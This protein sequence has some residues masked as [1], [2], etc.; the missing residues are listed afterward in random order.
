M[1][2]EGGFV[3]RVDLFMQLS[4]LLCVL[5][6]FSGTVNAQ[7][8]AAQPMAPLASVQ[9][10]AVITA[11][12]NLR[13]QP[14]MQGAVLTVVQ[15]ETVV[16]TLNKSGSWEHVQTENGT[17]GWIHTSLLV[18]SQKA[19]ILHVVPALAPASLPQQRPNEQQAAVSGTEQSVPH[20]HST[21][22]SKKP[23][24]FPS[25]DLLLPTERTQP[26]Q[27]ATLS[28]ARR[29]ILLAP[30]SPTGTDDTTSIT[31]SPARREILLAPDSPVDAAQP[32]QSPIFPETNPPPLED[33]DT[34]ASADKTDTGIYEDADEDGGLFGRS[35]L[36]Y[37]LAAL[38]VG[39]LGIFVFQIKKAREIK[40]HIYVFGQDTRYPTLTWQPGDDLKPF[41][42]PIQAEQ[43]LEAE[44]TDQKVQDPAFQYQ[45]DPFLQQADA[46][47]A[48]QDQDMP[49]VGEEESF[50]DSLFLET[51]KEDSQTA[52]LKDPQA[53]SSAGQPVGLIEPQS[54]PPEQPSFSPDNHP[55]NYGEA[56]P[57]QEFSSLPPL[58][59]LPVEFSVVEKAVL[60]A[61][62]TQEE[63]PE[64]ELKEMLAK[65]GFPVMLLKAVIGD[66]MRKTGSNGIPWIRVHYTQGAFRYQRQYLPTH[67]NGL[68]VKNYGNGQEQVTNG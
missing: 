41:L 44:Q 45:E 12:A 43:P 23:L 56:A 15:A 17:F 19:G 50:I 5:S 40:Q 59:D 30:D 60:E 28:P 34:S 67:L 52:S 26:A 33:R 47:L 54:I 29:E 37:I 68:S 22:V 21:S 64:Y 8:Q 62:F 27:H 25:P 16:Q 11:N 53:A 35:R 63:V 2:S 57:A 20:S 65:R 48:E 36:L 39:A 13:A 24:I 31:L 46:A 55:H 3:S 66:L 51:I 1:R 18:P 7:D 58:P 32:K 38:V 42:P 9:R 10:H 4:T 61:I 6:C 14:S 49:E